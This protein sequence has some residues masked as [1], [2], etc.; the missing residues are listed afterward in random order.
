[1]G[2]VLMRFNYMK[3]D[4]ICS[5]I[6]VYKDYTVKVEDFTS[7]IVDLPFGT[8]GSSATVEDVFDLFERRCLPSNRANIRELL[9]NKEF[10]ALSI[11]KQINHGVMACDTFWIKFDYETDLTWGKVSRILKL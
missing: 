6:T 4:F 5:T 3:E 7:V 10:S 11:I 2:K 9:G 1:M 8:W